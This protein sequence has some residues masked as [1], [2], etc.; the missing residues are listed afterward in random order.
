MVSFVLCSHILSFKRLFHRLSRFS[1]SENPILSVISNAILLL[2]FSASNGN[3]F[4]QGA[5]I[6]THYL[7]KIKKISKL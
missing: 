7:F 1:K 3:I 6:L 2:D 5:A 4:P